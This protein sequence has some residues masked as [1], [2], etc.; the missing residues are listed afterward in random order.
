MPAA[1]AVDREAVK[2]HAI[3]HGIREAARAFELPEDTVC[4]WSKRYGW[5]ANAGKA[6]VA[7][8]LPKSMQAPVSNV[9]ITPS[10]AAQRSKMDV[11]AQTH[12]L[13]SK[14]T[15]T[16]AKGMARKSPDAIH[17]AVD[18]L[19]KLTQAADKLHGYSKD[20]APTS[21]PLLLLSITGCPS[22]CIQE[23]QAPTE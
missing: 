3:T 18:V 20:S 22:V 15:L 17:D 23:G 9:S 19:L 10:E 1:L 5:L 14:A 13:L 8:P 12:H 6:I 7:Q 21:T 11:K 2:A 16:G 4:Q